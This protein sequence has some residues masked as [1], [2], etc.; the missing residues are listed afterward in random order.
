MKRIFLASVFAAA[1]VPLMSPAHATPIGSPTF[2]V[3]YSVGSGPIT[4]LAT[5]VS[6]PYIFSVGQIT[7]SAANFGTMTEFNLAVQG[8]DPFT[9]AATIYLTE[10]GLTGTGRMSVSGTLTNNTRLTP[11]ASDLIYTL[12]GSTSNAAFT[13]TALGSQTI[14]STSS[15]AGIDSA[16]FSATGQYSLTQAIT[17]VPG[18]SGATNLS[19]DGVVNVPEPSSFALL[20]T[21]LFALGLLIRKRQKRG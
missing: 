3:G 10:V 2:D 17:I 4:A 19:L 12:Y 13:G 20:G 14:L 7:L 15:T 9:S 11:M 21:G 1:S 16:I 8:G 5:N 6:G 18:T